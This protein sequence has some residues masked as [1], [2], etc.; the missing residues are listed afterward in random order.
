MV[1]AVRVGL[2]AKSA[3]PAAAVRAATTVARWSSGRMG[4]AD[5]ASFRLYPSPPPDGC[6][7]RLMAEPTLMPES[8]RPFLERFFF[9]P[10]GLRAGWRFAMFLVLVIVL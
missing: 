6:Y 5:L 3:M 2:A 9:G 7:L 1:R 10:F 4:E 8:D